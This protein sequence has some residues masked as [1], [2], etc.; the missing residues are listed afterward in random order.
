MQAAKAAGAAGNLETALSHYT[1]AFRAADTPEQK[2]DV[3]FARHQLLLQ[4]K[5]GGDAE[6]LLTVFLK[7]ESL[8]PAARRRTL[9]ALAGHIMWG[10]ADEAK[11]YLDQA[12]TI[13]AADTDDQVRASITRGYVYKIRGQPDN[14]LE[15]WLPILELR[16]EVHPAH[17]SSIS[18]QIGVIYRQKNDAEN[19]RKY[20][21]L[22]V[23]NG[24]KVKYQFDYS[25][26]EKALE[27]LKERK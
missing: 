11:Q 15:V 17:L 26:S 22:A 25:A 27:N 9:V 16:A 8:P 7:D 10:R 5:R 24:K 4:S 18:H 13:P 20:F 6:E 12:A 14:A 2:T 19:A 3:V 1:A 23:D 21:Q